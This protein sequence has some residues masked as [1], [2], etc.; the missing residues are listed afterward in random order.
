MPESKVRGV[1]PAGTVEIEHMDMR[2]PGRALIEQALAQDLAALDEST[3]KA[4]F[5]AYGIPVTPGD[6]VNDEEGAVAAAS[7]LGYPV[8]M[9][10]LS[11]EIMHKT[12]A[13]L[14]LLDVDDEEAVR[15]AYHLLERRGEGRLQGILVEKMVPRSREFVV[16]MS[17]DPQFGPV[18]MFGVGGVLTE[19]LQDVAFGVAP[20]SDR[21]VSGLLGS[22]RAAGLLGPFRG[23]PA[24]DKEQLTGIVEA[25]CQMALDHPE[26]RE[27]DVNPVLI[28]GSIPVAVDALVTLAEPPA[29]PEG[30]LPVVL[31]ALDAV[32]SPQVVAVVGASNDPTKWGGTIMNNLLSG[33]FPGKVYPVNPKAGTVFGLPAFAGV[34]ELPQTPDLALIAV[35]ARFVA[36]VV[37]ACG[38]QGVRAVVVISSGF[39]EVSAEGAAMEREV[40]RLA[41]D[42]GMAMIGPNC[43]GVMSSWSRLYATGAIIMH[44]ATGP[45]SFLSQSGNMGIQ[46][47]AAAED[48]KGGIG[49]FV[50]IGNEALFDATD[51]FEYFRDDPQTGVILAYIEG[52]D[53]GRRF[54]EIARQATVEKPVIVLRSAISDF[55][56]KAALSHTGAMAG[57]AKVYEAV[58]RQS[59]IISTTDPDEFLDLAFSL[60][61][62]PLPKGRRVAI[63]T[64][65]GGWGVLSADEVWRTGLELVD[66]PADV[67]AEI[68]EVLPPF[69]SHG[70]PVDLVGTMTNEAP[71]RAVEAAVRSVAVDAVI[72]LG[73]VGQ[74]A[75]RQRA[76]ETARSFLVPGT[77]PAELEAASKD[78]YLAREAAFIHRVGELM[79][80]YHKPIIN[81]SFTPL[82]QAVFQNEGAYSAVVLPSPLRSVRVVAKMAGYRDF[83]ASRGVAGV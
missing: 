67:I 74:G 9:K 15:G 29:P 20:L 6:V 72:V 18:V 57:S 48:R 40:A 25:V 79:N 81:V 47:M 10:G 71:E 75:G 49:K 26:I 19:A 12:D 68:S 13:G 27:I 82:D 64:M 41:S 35:P 60:S 34:D 11:R 56:R 1:D 14:V 76:I 52:F 33:E 66:L 7:R 5:R 23:A 37:E 65:G 4:L 51:L 3:A 45:A 63:I 61:Y 80:R 38:R 24:V 17:R 16:G 31:S 2:A 78:D 53:D 73:V 50:G 32:F 83:L 39:S 28:D 21:E 30:R 44:P 55:G 22:I 8:V 59:G 43:M 58:V 42:Y 54:M 62:M 69:W 36:G 70:N 46:L 77:V